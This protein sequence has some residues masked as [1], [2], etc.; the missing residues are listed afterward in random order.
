[1]NKEFFQLNEGRKLV[2]E[3][4]KQKWENYQDRRR[5]RST[6]HILEQK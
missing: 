5:S 1:L 2:V 3:D 6:N 4:I